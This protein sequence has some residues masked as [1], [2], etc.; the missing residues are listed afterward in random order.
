MCCFRWEGKITYFSFVFH[1][2]HLAAQV[3]HHHHQ[4]KIHRE[5]SYASEKFATTS[6]QMIQRKVSWLAFVH[7][8][9][10]LISPGGGLPSLKTNSSGT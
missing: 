1:P 9:L 7:A 6:R 5:N 4:Q 2:G 8:E 10:L 3:K